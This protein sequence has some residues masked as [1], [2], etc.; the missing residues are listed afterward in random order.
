[1]I[2]GAAKKS[3]WFL[4]LLALAAPA[5]AETPSKT[6]VTMIKA[7]T[8][9]RHAS[10]VPADCWRMGPLRLG[11]KLALVRTVLG[12]PDT[13]QDALL[14]YRRKKIAMTRLFYVYPRNLANWLRLAPQKETAFHPVTLKLDFSK[15]VLVAVAV[16]H[17]IH[18]TFPPCTPRVGGRGFV[19]KP[20]GFPYGFHGLTLGASLA[21]VEDRFGKF[22][23]SNAAKDFHIYGPLPLSV[24]GKDAVSGFR[25]ATGAPF[26]SGGGTPEFQ[27]KLDPRTCF[28]TGY[29]L[30]PGA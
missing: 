14:T 5:L 11:M 19:Q 18:I 30:D 27:L 20:A 1:M 2:F 29:E 16:D 6:C 24:E 8:G 4:I 3:F 12:A 9:K 13:S 26:E 28:V 25:F 23:S 21:S 22:A 15:D 7:A 17:D 10:A